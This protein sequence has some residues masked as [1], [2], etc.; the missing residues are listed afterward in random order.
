MRELAHR[1]AGEHRERGARADTGDADEL[2]EGTALFA[3]GEA[4][5]VVRVLAHDEMREEA[6]RLAVGRQRVERAHRYV[7]LVGDAADIDQHLRRMLR[8]E[9]P[10]EAADQTSLPLRMRSPRVAR[11]P[12]CAPCAWQMAQA[13]ASAASGEGSPGSASSRRTMCCTCCFAA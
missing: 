6:H 13:S 2:A 4:V 11:R 7:E 1:H 5:E 3:G 9:P 12:S 8:R 10:G